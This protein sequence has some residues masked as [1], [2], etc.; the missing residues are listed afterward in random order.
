MSDTIMLIKSEDE[1][2]EKDTL[3]EGSEHATLTNDLEKL[4]IAA[5]PRLARL[6]RARG[7]ALDGVEDVVQET[8]MEAWRNLEYLHAPDRFD[9]WL[10]GICRNVSMRWIR[11][12]GTID[13]RQRTFSSL[14]LIQDTDIDIPTL[15]IPDPQTLDLAEELN[16]QDLAVLLDRAMGHLPATTRKVLE[17]HYITEVPQR[18]MALRLG[19]TINTLEVKLHRA[20]RQLRQVLNGELRADAESFGLTLDKVVVQGWRETSLWCLICGRQRLQ[21]IFEPCSG[22]DVSLRLQCPACSSN[23]GIDI[24]NTGNMVSL[25]DIRSFRPAIK[26]ILQTVPI[27]YTQMFATKYQPCPVCKSL[28][29]LRGVEPDVL[30]APFY[31]RFGIVLECPICGKITSSILSLCLTYPPAYQFIMQHQRCIV[32]PEES[33][34]Y[35]GQPAIRA[36]L[37][38]ILSAEQLTMILHRHTLQLLT[39][40]QK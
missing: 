17:M 6:A 39:V 8:L 33:I 14:Q 35:E 27:F 20:R 10:N 9:A 3:A 23:G 21:G 7:V 34:E 22:G 40:F 18:E 30:P 15:D 38:D 16:R 5:Q 36:G 11:A 26:R 37:T 1:T 19:I 24:V 25:K 12:Q 4:L 2:M 13:H 29:T 32:E 31:R 28:A